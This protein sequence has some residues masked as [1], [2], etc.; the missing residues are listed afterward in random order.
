MS[1]N[2]AVMETDE[3]LVLAPTREVAR[4]EIGTELSADEVEV[5]TSVGEL[6]EVME[7]NL[8]AVGEHYREGRPRKETI[9]F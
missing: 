2:T 9:E 5:V 3:R 8:N 6:K 7:P 1:I 4:N